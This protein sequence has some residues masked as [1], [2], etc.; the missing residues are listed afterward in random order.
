MGK[1]ATKKEKAVSGLQ[2]SD[3]GVSKSLKSNVLEISEPEKN[4]S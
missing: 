2:N 1:S 3:F 4:Q